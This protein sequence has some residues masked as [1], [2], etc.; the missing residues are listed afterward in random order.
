MAKKKKSRFCPALNQDISSVKCGQNRHSQYNCP[1]SC[2]Y[3]PFHPDNYDQFLDL[4]SEV[5]NTIMDR[6]YRVPLFA[7]L[8]DK[9]ISKPNENS[10]LFTA[11]VLKILHVSQG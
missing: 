2:T 9:L 11:E 1:T 3:S 4:E 7:N 8:T 10:F 5:Q 6:L